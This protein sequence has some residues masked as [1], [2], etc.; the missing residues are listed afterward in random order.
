MTGRHMSGGHMPSHRLDQLHRDNSTPPADLWRRAVTRRHSGVTL[1]GPPRLRVSVDYDDV[2]SFSSYSLHS[3]IFTV[4]ST[5]HST[6]CHDVPILPH[7][8]HSDQSILCTD[9]NVDSFQ[10][11]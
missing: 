11:E 5:T 8:V 10:T 9:I 3:L 2:I 4:M 6:A 1:Y 7:G